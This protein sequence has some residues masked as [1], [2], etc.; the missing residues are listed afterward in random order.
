LTFRREIDWGILIKISPLLEIIVPKGLKSNVGEMR[1]QIGYECAAIPVS[2]FVV[3]TRWF[4]QSKES[5]AII[6]QRV[7]LGYAYG[8][9]SI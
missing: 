3:C 7:L 2:A 9:G 5:I 8:S 1:T 4:I 6:I